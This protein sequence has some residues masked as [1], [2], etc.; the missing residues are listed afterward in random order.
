MPLLAGADVFVSPSW[1][2]SF[3]YN[4]LEAMAAGLPV[5]A[6]DVGGTAEAVEHGVTGVVVPPQDPGA[7]TEAISG[8]LDDP[9]R[10][11]RLGEAGRRRVDEQ[12]GIERMIAGTLDVYRLAG[13]LP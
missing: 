5:V 3:P 13:A 7:L 4:V 10:A 9:E 8:L 2:E 12:F 6:T 11:S 1:A